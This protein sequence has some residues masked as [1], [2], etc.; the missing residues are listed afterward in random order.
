[1]TIY[2]SASWKPPD[3]GW[4]LPD[5]SHW[6]AMSRTVPIP[7][8]RMPAV[9]HTETAF[10]R[11]HSHASFAL[12]TVTSQAVRVLNHRFSHWRAEQSN[13]TCTVWPASTAY[14]SMLAF[15]SCRHRLC[16]LL[17][18]V[19]RTNSRLFHSLPEVLPT[20]SFMGSTAITFPCISIFNRFYL[21]ECHN[22]HLHL[23]LR[24]YF[25]DFESGF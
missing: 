17:S 3:S 24:L 16:G 4:S 7:T 21:A 8:G 2:G 22:R 25:I 20:P 23:F 11:I 18:S 6:Y 1:M 12:M 14:R 13:F 5:R 9:P 19:S 10:S 15:I